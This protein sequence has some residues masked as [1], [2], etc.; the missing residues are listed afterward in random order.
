MTPFR[1]MGVIHYDALAQGIQ[2]GNRYSY[3]FRPTRDWTAEKPVYWCEVTQLH[4][5]RKVSQVTLTKVSAETGVTLKTFHTLRAMVNFVEKFFPGEEVLTL[6]LEIPDY[7]S[8]D[9]E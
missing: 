7:S 3:R 2:A 4:P 8:E 1:R 5:V 6:P 9:G